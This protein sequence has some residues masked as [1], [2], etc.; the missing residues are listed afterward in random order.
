[1]PARTKLIRLSLLVEPLERILA[2]VDGP[3]FEP[4]VHLVGLLLGVEAMERGGLVLALV[5]QAE[6]D[7]GRA[8]GRQGGDLDAPEDVRA[9]GRRADAGLVEVV[10]REGC[11]I[12][13]AEV[14]LGYGVSFVGCEVWDVGREGDIRL[15]ESIPSRALVRGLL[16]ATGPIGLQL[17][18]RCTYYRARGEAG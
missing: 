7:I 5:A 9:V 13:V 4:A 8:V 12:L 6:E 1:M 2:S 3:V 15:P 17:P 10:G 11:Q 14:G 18:R 16:L